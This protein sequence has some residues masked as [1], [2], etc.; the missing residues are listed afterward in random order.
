MEG[1]DVK[2]RNPMRK[3]FMSEILLLSLIVLAVTS[4]RHT[5]ST[6]QEID[7]KQTNFY[8]PCKYDLTSVKVK[9]PKKPTTTKSRRRQRRAIA[10]QSRGR[11]PSEVSEKGGRKRKSG[12]KKEK[13]GKANRKQNKDRSNRKNRRKITVSSL[14][15]YASEDKKYQCLPL[16]ITIH[17]KNVTIACFPFQI[18]VTKTVPPGLVT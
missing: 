1:S 11:T 17:K 16:T 3:L 2:M 12:G 14:N 7:V 8:T 4:A 10:K 5:S 6:N 13:S 18:P 9:V 15:C